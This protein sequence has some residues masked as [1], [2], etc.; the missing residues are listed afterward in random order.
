[1]FIWNNIMP[2]RSY[3]GNVVEEVSRSD[4]G[5]GNAAVLQY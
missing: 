5:N 2:H 4:H 3:S 1:M